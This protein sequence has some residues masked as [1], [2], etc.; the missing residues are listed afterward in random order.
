MIPQHYRII[1]TYNYS[2][3]EKNRIQLF[4]AISSSDLSS[5]SIIPRPSHPTAPRTPVKQVSR[6]KSGATPKEGKAGF[7]KKKAPSNYAWRALKGAGR[8]A[9]M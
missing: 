8:W 9:S 1:E 3:D 7:R 4:H 6:Q 2:I 5:L